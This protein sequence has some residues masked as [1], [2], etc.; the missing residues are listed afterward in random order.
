METLCP[1]LDGGR[2]ASSDELTLGSILRAFLPDGLQ[3]LKLGSHR[4]RVLQ[5]LAACGTAAMG[6]NLFECPH[7]Q[8][9]HWGPRSCGDRHCPHCRGGKSRQWL[10]KQTRSLLPIA[11]YHCVFTVPAELNHLALVNQRELYPLFLDCAAQSLLEF[12]RNRLRGDLGISAVLHTWGQKL[13]FH[14]HLH[15]IVTGGALSQDKKHWRSPKQRRFL[16]PV[17]ELA[18]LF[19]GKFLAGLRQLLDENKLLIPE[20]TT[21]TAS[22]HIGLLSLLYSKPWV[23]YAKRPFG[24]PQQVLSYLA[25]YTHRV[26][27]SNRRIIA[28]DA[29][30][31]TITFTYRDYRCGSQVKEL[32]LSAFEFIRRFS[33]HVL[34]SGLVRIRHYGILGNGRRSHDVESARAILKRRGYALELESNNITD[35]PM[36]CPSCGR[37]GIQLL[38]FIDFAGVL[39]LRRN[40]QTAYDSS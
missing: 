27:L 6:A 5:H 8:H 9:R 7:C 20:H 26:A 14:P 38:A 11:Y 35:K 25:N 36:C 22:T 33:L 28:V 34:P 16:F 23:V 4:L 37:T 17:R 40:A 21:K 3:E 24:G 32:T 30:Q 2:E 13:E 29:A 10:D 19:R 1:S 18:A 31:K 15:C 12:G 39:H